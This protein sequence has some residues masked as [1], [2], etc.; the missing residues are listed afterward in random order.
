VQTRS[1]IPL[2]VEESDGN[3]VTPFQGFVH[4]SVEIGRIVRGILLKGAPLD[5]LVGE[6]GAIA[7]FCPPATTYPTGAHAAVVEVDPKTAEIRILHYAAVEDFG[8]L[9]NPL[10]VDGQVIGGVAHG[11]GNTFL[12]RVVYTDDGQILTGTL[13]DYL[14]PTAADVPRVDLD[15]L[16]TPSP[17]NPL[18]A[19][20]AGQGGLIPVAAVLTAA[21]EDALRPFGVKLT[22][23]PFT[24]S[25]LAEAIETGRPAGGSRA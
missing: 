6:I 25:D 8:T 11:I 17:L 14:M 2:S 12:E 20:G 5:S 22:R 13:M 4:R 15:H 23:V 3:L 9:M 7:A 21:V 18:G 16:G 10:I 19:K 24:P 1:W